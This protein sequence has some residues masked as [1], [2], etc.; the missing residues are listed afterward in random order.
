M[1]KSKRNL[2]YHYKMQS[3]RLC[4]LLNIRLCMSVTQAIY[5]QI[6]ICSSRRFHVFWRHQF[7]RAKRKESILGQNPHDTH[8]QGLNIANI[9]QD[10]PR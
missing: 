10:I 2:V 4:H 1:F 8:Q 3:M 7:L 6:V 9:D 5:W